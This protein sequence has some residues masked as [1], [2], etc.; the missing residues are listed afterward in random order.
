MHE[1]P[2]LLE[3][4]PPVAGRP[5]RATSYQSLPRRDLVL[6][7]VGLMLTLLL[8]ALDQTI[9]GT[10]M[11]RIVA[12]LQGFEHYAWVTT[13]YLLTSTAVVPISGK[14]SD[15][16]GRKMFLLGS[17]AL[18]VLTSA[19]C[20]LSQDMTELI[21]FRALQGIAGGV[22]TSTVFTVISQIFPPAERARFQGIFSGIF[23]FASIVGPLLGGYLTDNLSWRWVFYVNLPIGII[24]FTVLVLS[25]PNIRPV[26]RQRQIDFLGAITLVLGVV[27]LLLAL[28][29]GG[30]DYAW[31]S[32]MVIGLFVLAAVM[33]VVF[34]LVESRA[35]EP[36]IPLS[37][38]RNRI[39]SVSVVAMSIM[40]VGMFGTI[41][42]IPLYIQ[43]VIGTDATD[44]GTVLMPLMITMIGSSVIAGQI[45]SRTGRYKLS[46]VIGMIGM[47]I[48][49]Y[50]LSGMGPDTDYLTVVRNMIIIGL[51][52]G[53]TMPVFTLAAQNAVR[54][55]QLG[56]VTSLTQFARSM[57]STLGVALFGSLLTNDF[58][59]SFRAAL[60]P[61]VTASVPPAVL[62]QFDNPQV[63]LSPDLANALRQQVL[64][65]GPQGA[66]LFDSLYA[67][68][69]IGLV[70]AL[71]DVFFV[72]AVLGVVGV[73][74]TLLLKELPL[75]KSYAPS[76]EVTLTET[77]AQVGKDAF[78]SLPPL[79]P[80]DQPVMPAGGRENGLVA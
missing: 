34:G 59:P 80:E 53:P 19:M 55:N 3:E 57:G 31:N 18:F 38:F 72:G 69:K 12:D 17:S 2:I 52:M 8:S 61:E 41:L 6:T 56:V 16:Y 29:W 36:I 68:I 9:V 35:I 11:P 43:G 71:H 22:L 48:G 65:L 64:N 32:P 73:L 30:N 47:A 23:G 42:F 4:A 74:V 63:L 33:L 46:G 1:S 54:M 28:S 39:V 40:S 10:A 76:S 78:P 25:F 50:L 44:S 24:A 51:G 5:A 66:Q 60:S 13:A 58:T 21:V 37:L 15:M 7:V 14:L 26:A 75:R 79:R 27:P 70:G 20:G 49:L 62:G 45:I 67:A 77:A